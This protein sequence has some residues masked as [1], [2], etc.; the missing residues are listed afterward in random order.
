MEIAMEIPTG[1]VYRHMDYGS[2]NSNYYIVYFKLWIRQIDVRGT[3][4]DDDAAAV[5]T[6]HEQSS[7]S[8]VPQ[9]KIGL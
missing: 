2:L 7:W 9:N 6:E 8:R 4:E 1:P 5:K 3:G